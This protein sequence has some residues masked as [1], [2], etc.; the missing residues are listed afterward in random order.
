MASLCSLEKEFK[1][2]NFERY[3]LFDGNLLVQFGRHLGG[4]GYVSAV[5]E[6]ETGRH[7]GGEGHAIVHEG[8]RSGTGDV[9]PLGASCTT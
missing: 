9:L 7:S 1:S 8:Q 4:I 2:K 3:K 5:H 6:P